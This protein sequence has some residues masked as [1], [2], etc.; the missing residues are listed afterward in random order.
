MAYQATRMLKEAGEKISDLDTTP[1]D[2]KLEELRSLITKDDQPIDIDDLD[3]AAV[4]AKMAEVEEELHGISSKL[5][6]A[7]AAEMSE[8][9]S[10]GS[11]EVVEADF[12]VVDSDEENE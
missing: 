6:E 10:D 5:Y 2:A 1:I 4:Q 11:E 8:Q 7:A 12:E 3:E 9:D